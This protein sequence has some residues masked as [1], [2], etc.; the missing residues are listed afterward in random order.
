MIFP[1]YEFR[2]FCLSSDSDK[3]SAFNQHFHSI[4]NQTSFEIPSISDLP[5]PSTFI[6]E[7][8]MAEFDVFNA[9][10]SLDQ[11][12]SMGIKGIGPR[13]LKHF[14]VPLYQLMFHLFS[15][16][17][18]QYYLRFCRQK[19]SQIRLLKP[20]HSFSVF[21]ECCIETLLASLH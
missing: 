16:S 5:R 20:I 11:T 19:R 14:A 3:P 6:G 8:S 21:I 9:L 10:V 2:Y 13:L 4:F 17:L 18:P 12:K 1:I 7:I 15:L